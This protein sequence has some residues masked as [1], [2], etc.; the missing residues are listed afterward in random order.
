MCVIHWTGLAG[1]DSQLL[2]SRLTGEVR[3]KTHFGG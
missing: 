3:T 1:I 2:I